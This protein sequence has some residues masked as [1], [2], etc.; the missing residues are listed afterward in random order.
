[1]PVRDIYFTGS[2]VLLGTRGFELY[3]LGGMTSCRVELSDNTH[4]D[5]HLMQCIF[6]DP[7]VH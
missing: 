1:M 2:Q 5:S 3:R 6:S 4:V 7:S